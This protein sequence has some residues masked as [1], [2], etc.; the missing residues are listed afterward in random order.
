MDSSAI[1][2]VAAFAL[3][4]LFVFIR[5]ILWQIRHIVTCLKKYPII[6][7]DMRNTGSNT[8]TDDLVFL[9]VCSP[10]FLPEAYEDLGEERAQ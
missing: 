2:S 8:G 7:I 6:Q 4:V 5:H 3:P 10:R 9:C 1:V